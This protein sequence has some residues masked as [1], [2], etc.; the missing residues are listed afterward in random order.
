MRG[1]LSVQFIAHLRVDCAL[2]QSVMTLYDMAPP[3]WAA[4]ILAGL[5]LIT[6]HLNAPKKY[7]RSR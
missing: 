2:A 3:I 5:D 7:E 1:V 6:G 4:S